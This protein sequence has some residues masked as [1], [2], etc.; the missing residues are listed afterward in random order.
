[1]TLAAYTIGLVPFVLIR[2]VVAPFLA[3]GDTATPVKAALT[4]TAVNIVF[5]IALMGPLAQV[6]LALATSIGAW[7][8]FALVLW[9][10]GARR[11]HR[12]R[13]RAQISLGQARGG[14]NRHRRS[15]LLSLRRSSS[16]V[17]SSLSKFR[18]EAELV[19]LAIVGGAFWGVACASHCLDADGCRFCA[20][21]HKRRPPRQ[22][23]RSRARHRLPRDLTIYEV[24]FLMEWRQ[25]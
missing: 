15:F 13:R 24:N 21:G 20:S 14:W 11:P 4:G 19:A 17:F 9:F 16:S 22:S 6:G 12:C 1:M 8:N 2:S 5:K 10:A 18:G 3:R 23:R 25:F 7:I